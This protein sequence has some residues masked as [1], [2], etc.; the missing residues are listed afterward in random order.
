LSPPRPQPPGSVAPRPGRRR[1]RTYLARYWGAF[2]V[3]LVF[4]VLTQAFALSVP[5]LLRWATDGLL[6][7]DLGR[8][9]DVAFGLIAVALAGAL[10]R[11][12]SRIFIFNSGRRVEY[13]I[14]T[15]AFGHLS[16]LPPSFY[17]GMPLAQVMTRLVNDLTQVRLLLGPGL[18][19][20]S[21]TLLVYL[22]A[23][24]LLFA[25]D[26]VLALYALL[27]L[28][29]LVFLGRAFAKLIYPMSREAQDRLGTLSTK[30]QETLSGTMTV[31][32]YGEETGEE[33]RFQRLN[34]R[35]LDINLQLARLR[36]ILF[37]MMG[38]AGGIGGVVVLGVGGYR[39]AS[40]VLTV[41]QFVEFNAYLAA[42]TWPTIALGW[43]ISLWNRGIASMDRINEIFAVYP[44]LDDGTR[45][46]PP[47]EGH[48]AVR[49]LT[50]TYGEKRA[51]DD[52]CFEVHPGETVL[53]VGKTGAG[54]S[55]LMKVLSRLI[56]VDRG[57][58]FLDGVD[59]NDLP[60]DHVRGHLAYAAQDAFLFSR[61]LAENIAFGR[62]DADLDDVERA[63]REAA[64]A[65]DVDAFPDGLATMVGERGI[66][67]SGGQRQRT[68][69]ARAL[70]VEAPILLLDDT[71]SAVDT[72]TETKILDALQSHRRD[73]SLVLA[74]HRLGAAAWAD[75]IY[76][77]EEGRII[78]CGTEAELLRRG[79]AYARLKEEAPAAA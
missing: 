65:I 62:P 51:L 35:Y 74:S 40:G 72:E 22:V 36:G 57:T 71:L 25:S 21:N 70:L 56:E 58:T 31:R 39:I 47:F 14:R 54:K 41:G 5:R 67:L 24:P 55:T 44:A 61:S 43:T 18:L 38:L 10:A 34:A 12:A 79:G 15:D 33:D 45:T 46:P 48:L 77:L 78:E 23:L 17:A 66:T 11:I 64:L 1:I 16:R 13:D 28:P 32:V 59:V 49:H 37:P 7:D 8:V 53:V 52:V 50:V 75:R 73:R 69:L 60:L 9:R 76:V 2:A 4:L 63:V 3:G 19:N 29:I 20:L 27:P 6:G 42:L 30:V 68:T 26:W